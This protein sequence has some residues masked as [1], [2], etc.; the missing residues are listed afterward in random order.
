MLCVRSKAFACFLTN[1]V[2]KTQRRAGA[3]P[4]WTDGSSCAKRKRG[5][6]SLRKRLLQWG[7]RALD[8]GLRVQPAE[9]D[10]C[11]SQG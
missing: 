4:D 5:T 6:D 10:D 2:G 8:S 7:R 9:R 1:S 3:A 11:T